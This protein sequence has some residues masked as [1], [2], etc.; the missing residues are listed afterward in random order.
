MLEKKLIICVLTLTVLERALLT[1]QET[2]LS[3]LRMDNS[4]HYGRR[5]HFVE[6]AKSTFSGITE[7][8]RLQYLAVHPACRHRGVASLFLDWGKQQAEREG[9]PIR[10]GSSELARPLYLK[11]GFRRYG[12]IRIKDF[13]IENVPTFLWEPRGMEGRW[14]VKGD[15]TGGLE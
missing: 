4:L 2:Y 3:L 5:D 6:E 9:V 13:P 7:F 1:T 11:N 10:L 14:G 12:R 8:W 15:D